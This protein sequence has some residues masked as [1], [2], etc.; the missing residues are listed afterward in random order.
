MT[1]DGGRGLDLRRSRR[2]RASSLVLVSI[3]WLVGCGGSTRST[4]KLEAAIVSK[5][6]ASV[7]GKKT[8]L[9]AVAAPTCRSTRLAGNYICTGRPTFASCPRRESPAQTCASPTAPTEVWLA[10]FTSPGRPAFDCQ[11]QDPPAGTDVFVTAAQRSATKKAE[12][13]CLTNTADGASIGPLTITTANSFGPVE[14]TP[15]YVTRTQA[16]ALARAAGARL[17]ID[18]D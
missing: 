1:V 9:V 7:F 18:C 10:C 3:C 16:K 5:Q 14:T 17:A 11:T 6:V 13:T 12:W 4:A 2:L 8:G 15:N